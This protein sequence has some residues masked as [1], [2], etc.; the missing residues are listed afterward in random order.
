MLRAI[1]YDVSHG[2]TYHAIADGSRSRFLR[3]EL[4]LAQGDTSVAKALYRGFDE[5]WSPWDMYHRPIAY[6]RLGEIAEAEGRVSEAITYYSRLVDL[7]RDCDAEMVATR[8]KMKQRRDV[9]QA[10]RR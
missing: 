3:A 8:D 6:Q 7:W 2:A 1:T 5:S 9:L 10:S 4:E